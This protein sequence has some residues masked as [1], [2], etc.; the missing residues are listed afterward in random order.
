MFKRFYFIFCLCCFLLA[1]FAW[2]VKVWIHV[3]RSIVVWRIQ[4]EKQA[5][6]FPAV[7]VLFFECKRIGYLLRVCLPCRVSR[8][9]VL[10]ALTVWQRKRKRSS[11]IYWLYIFNSSLMLWQSSGRRS[12]R[13]FLLTQIF[14]NGIRHIICYVAGCC[15]CLRDCFMLFRFTACCMML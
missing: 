5:D 6:I 15:L 1:G 3:K 7:G 14:Y 12:S 4:G 8:S 2:A 13:Y 9:S 10:S 11:W